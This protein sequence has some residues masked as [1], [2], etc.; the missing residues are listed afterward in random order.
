MSEA[1][2]IQLY[3]YGSPKL[4]LEGGKPSRAKIAAFLTEVG[5]L[6]FRL[7][8]LEPG[9]FFFF[10]SMLK[11]FFLSEA[12]CE[13]VIFFCIHFILYFCSF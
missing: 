1:I 6:S 12:F 8:V 2:K 7:S 4:S 9:I 5:V 11:L 10:P 3:Y 13:I